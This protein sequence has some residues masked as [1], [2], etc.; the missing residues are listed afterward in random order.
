MKNATLKDE[1]AL[2][3]F[4]AFA[5]RRRRA[6]SAIAEAVSS[7]VAAAHTRPLT[8]TIYHILHLFIASLE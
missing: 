2:R 4:P 3:Q 8:D 6:G 7:K 1:R 5:L